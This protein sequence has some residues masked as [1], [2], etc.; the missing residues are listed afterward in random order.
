MSRQTRIIKKKTD[1]I[2]WSWMNLFDE[3]DD[4]NVVIPKEDPT[5]FM[6][7]IKVKEE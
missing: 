5:T 6:V 4:I 1:K 7:S 3:I 2:L